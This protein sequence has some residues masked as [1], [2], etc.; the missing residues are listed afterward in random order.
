M[1]TEGGLTAASCGVSGSCKLCRIAEA[2]AQRLQGNPA[3][4]DL[5]GIEFY[6]NIL[7][8]SGLG[9]AVGFGTRHAN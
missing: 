9:H 2:F 1:V 3:E 4:A 6:F 7:N 5:L 8:L